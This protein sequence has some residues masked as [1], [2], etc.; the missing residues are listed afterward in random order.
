MSRS[1]VV[2]AALAL[3]AC[4][5]SS[6]PRTNPSD[7]PLAGNPDGHSA[8]PSEART[9]DVSS[10]A[11]VIGNGTAASCTSTEVVRTVA[12]GGV[13]TFNCGADP[14]TITMEQ[15]AKIVNNTGP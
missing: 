6:D 1:L 7:G 12:L 3:T 11:H 8:I 9:E 4:G 10:P 5:G 15:T 2:F 14:V 13:I